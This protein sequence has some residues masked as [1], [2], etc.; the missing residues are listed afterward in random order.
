MFENTETD[1]IANKGILW[2]GS[3]HTKQFVFLPGPDRIFSSESID[4]NKGNEYK[5]GNHPVLSSDTLGP[6]VVNSS[7]KKVGTLQN[8]KTKN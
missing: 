4:V 1:S 8:L 7:L 2:T 3:G 5:I 6:S